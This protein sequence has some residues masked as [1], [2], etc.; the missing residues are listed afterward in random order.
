MH[1]YIYI[2]ERNIVESVLLFAY[3]HTYGCRINAQENIAGL[4]TF[5][6][7]THLRCCSIDC[8][9][10]LWVDKILRSSPLT[11]PSRP[12][13]MIW[14]HKFLRPFP[15]M[16]SGPDQLTARWDLIR[17]LETFTIIVRETVG[18]PIYW[19]PRMYV[20]PLP[21]GPPLKNASDATALNTLNASP[22]ISRTRVLYLKKPHK[23]S[24]RAVIGQFE[25]V[26]ADT[27]SD[28]SSFCDIHWL[29]YVDAEKK[30]NK[31]AVK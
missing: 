11:P 20:Y 1:S 15:Q 17:D 7:V 25:H 26:H 12:S 18:T 29:S 22:I 5:L 4:W 13:V 19:N 24:L 28:C 6:V 21:D 31:R 10:L 23:R 27:I 30:R 14:M 16:S 2:Y 3:V 9:W 8:S